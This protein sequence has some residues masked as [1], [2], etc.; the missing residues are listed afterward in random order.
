LALYHWAEAGQSQVA[1]EEP[2][3]INVRLSMAGISRVYSFEFTSQNA[4]P[5]AMSY[6]DSQG[7]A[8]TLLDGRL[9]GTQNPDDGQLALRALATKSRRWAV[10]SQGT[11]DRDMGHLD[12]LGDSLG[13]VVEPDDRGR[14]AAGDSAA[15][16]L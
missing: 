12:S 9:I 3:K 13:A 15:N 4:T 14:L 8:G 2:G 16:A 10:G 7:V 5:V 6:N 11:R 1:Q